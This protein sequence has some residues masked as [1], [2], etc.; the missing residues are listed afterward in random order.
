MLAAT[1]GA[2]AQTFVATEPQRRNVLIEEY[3]GVGCQYCP[4]GHKATDQTVAAFPGRVFAINIHQGMFASQYTTQWGN[5]LASQAGI[6]GYPSSTLNR[7]AF[8]GGGIHIDP[9]Q[10]YMY[11]QEMM[12][13]EAPVNVAAT[14]DI[15]PAT[16]LMVVNVEVYYTDDAPGGSNMLNVALVQNDVLGSQAGAANFYPE[17]MVGGQ[18][19]H[20]HILRELLTGQWGDTIGNTSRGA[21]FS[22]EYAYVVPPRIGDLDVTDV[23]DLSVVV[24]VCQGR[25][26]V[27]NVCEAVRTGDKAYIAHASSG[28]RECAL[29]WTPYVTVVNPT[30][31]AISDM[32]FD[33]DGATLTSHKTIAP[34][35]SDTVRVADYSIDE[36]PAASASYGESV[37]VTFRSF[38]GGG[39][40]HAAQGTPVAIAYG[41]ADIYTAEGPLTLS[42]HYD[43]YPTEVSF[44]LAGLADCNY[45]YQ[46]TGGAGDASATRDYTLSPA[47]AGVYRLKVYDTGGDGLNGSVSLTDAQGNTLFSRSGSGLM[48]WDDIFVNIVNDG[49]DGPTAP[50]APLAG[51]AE[52]RQPMPELAVYPNPATEVASIYAGRTIRSVEIVNSLG[53][54]VASHRG[55]NA[56]IA[57]IDVAA[58]P[59]GV[60]IVRVTVDGGACTARLCVRK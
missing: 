5:A 53:Q 44:S 20:K 33:V 16:R 40:S 48:V 14:V 41:D 8:G 52:V 37:N 32:V 31:A 42:V 30:A 57:E 19:R 27:L 59:A 22:K 47:A 29:R 43:G 4:L 35:C 45:Y 3:T 15:D 12:A 54:T 6:S 17:N 39:S 49:T 7:H 25:T 46:T 21:F 2:G 55:V 38:S 36:M 1:W 23:D 34:Y 50:V 56:D 9:G 13:M 10:S 11:A 18:Y 26:E 28:G 51:I 58:M 60:Y 24:F